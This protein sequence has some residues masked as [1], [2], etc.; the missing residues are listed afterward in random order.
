MRGAGRAS[1]TPSPRLGEGAQ[2]G[3]AIGRRT[4]LGAIGVIGLCAVRLRAD[5]LPKAV[6]ASLLTAPIE[7]GG[8]WKWPNPSLRVL[9]RARDAALSGVRLVSD[10]QPARL[11]VDNHPSG[12]PAIWLHDQPEDTAW[13][14][15]DIGPSDWSK[16]AYQFGH[17]L[18]HVLCNSW[19]RSAA[20][21]PPTQWLEEAMVEAFSIRGLALLA[22]GWEHDPPFAGDAAFANAIRDYRQNLIARYGSGPG[23]DA[24]AWFRANRAKLESGAAT[25]EGSAVLAVLAVLED[26]PGCIEDLGA[27]NRWRSRTHV[28]IEEYLVLWQASCAELG[29]AGRLPARLKK[30]FLPA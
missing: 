3:A 9:G 4:L 27:A 20:P 14:I 26:D 16:L 29:A 2:A 12:P 21:G 17:E 11:R 13:V 8:E 18:G 10:R 6:A 28:P 25:P 15:V 23:A 30:L 5:P 22:I 19:N 1:G 7:L 24:A